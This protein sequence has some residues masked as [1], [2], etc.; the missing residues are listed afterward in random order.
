MICLIPKTGSTQ[1]EIKRIIRSGTA[2]P[3]FGVVRAL[4]QT[5]GR[6]R[7]GR[8][9]VA[10]GKD[11][12]LFSFGFH[13]RLPAG[14][15]FL[16]YQLAAVSVVEALRP[17]GI[18][19]V[20]KYPNDI[21]C[22]GRKLA[23]I[24]L[25]NQLQG[26]IIRYTVAG[27]GLNVN[28]TDF[29]PGLNAVSIRMITGHKTSVTDWIEDIG[30]RFRENMQGDDDEI[31]EKYLYYWMFEGPKKGIITVA[32]KR[33]EVAGWSWKGEQVIV[34]TPGGNSFTADMRQIRPF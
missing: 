21:L 10:D 11:N 34:Q 8:S 30:A 4:E 26:N 31:Q 24:L 33:V 15:S 13:H 32:G 27:I 1:D 9:W 23:G 6:G 7:F 14:R 17:K 16:L 28:Q 20:I 25:E 18:D 2:Y 22:E 19:A 5:G 29:P 3:D 12:A